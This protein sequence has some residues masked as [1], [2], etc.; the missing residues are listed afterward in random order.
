MTVLAATLTK[1]TLRDPCAWD[2]SFV[3]SVLCATHR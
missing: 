1:E 3:R 2:I